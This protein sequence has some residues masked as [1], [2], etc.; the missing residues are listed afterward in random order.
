MSRSSIVFQD[1]TAFPSMILLY[2]A[3]MPAVYQI[4]LIKHV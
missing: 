3:K 4:D 2:S 1:E